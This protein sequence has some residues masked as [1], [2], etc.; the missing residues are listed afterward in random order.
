MPAKFADCG[1]AFAAK[2]TERNARC[3]EKATETTTNPWTAV[4]LGVKMSERA[5]YLDAADAL[6]VRKA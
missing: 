2:S 1:G 4:L 3:D 5:L 6:I